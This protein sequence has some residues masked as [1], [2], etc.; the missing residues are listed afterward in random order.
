MPAK[1]VAKTTKK[2]EA[3]KEVAAKEKVTTKKAT[4]KT[5][6]TKAVTKTTEKKETVKKAEPKKSTTTKSA[7]K[8]AVAKKENQKAEVKKAE[9]K[10][11]TTAKKAAAK[12]EEAVKVAAK[13]TTKK[14]E[15][16]KATPAKKVETKPVATKAAV[17]K[18]E[19]T[20]K[21]ATKPATKKAEPKKATTTKTAAKKEVAKKE[22]KAPA[23]KKAEA[24]KAT[25][26]PAAK[27]AAT[28][29][30]AAK[31]VTTKKVTVSKAQQEKMDQY[32]SFSLETC[33]EMARAMGVEVSYD[34]IETKLLDEVDTKV[35]AAKIVSDY[36]VQEKGFTFDKDGYDADLIQAIVDRIASSVVVK[37][38]DFKGIGAEIKKH[39]K[40]TIKDDDSANNEEYHAMFDLVRRVLMMAQR[41]NVT[42]TLDMKKMIGESPEDLII[43]FMDLAYKILVHWTYDDVKYYE[44]FIYATL[45]QFDDMHE[46]YGVRAM[47][48]V[49]DLYIEHGDYGLGDA[50]YEYILRENQIK[51]YIYL[52]YAS[53]YYNS[54]DREKAKAIAH[55]SLQYVDDRYTYYPDIIS[56]LEN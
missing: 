21:V 18:K 35:L 29:K 46:K 42:S 27:K 40:Y 13:P 7:T 56:I 28:K 49:A 43:K 44:N 2:V 30:T 33:F 50:N 47:M 34:D 48:D 11:K 12:K 26:K 3:K 10:P 54:V 4:S 41:K 32:N 55:A 9:V 53:I 6:A 1:K 37:A 39:Q 25:A 51:D 22:T 45:S 38:S 16:K 24:K 19:E 17:A 31:K 14:A 5:T 23:T 15:A 20:S 8:T 36:G 52:R